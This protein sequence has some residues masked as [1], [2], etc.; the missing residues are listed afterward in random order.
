MNNL[1]S[2]ALKFTGQGDSITVS[3]T[4]FQEETHAKYQIVVKDTGI[5]MSEEFLPQLFEPYARETRFTAQKITGTGL[6]MPIVKNLVTQMSGQIQVESHL[7]QGTTFTLVLP[8]EAV[9]SQ[10]MEKTEDRETDQKSAQPAASGLT[11]RRILL[12]EDNEVNMEIATEILTSAGLEVT[13]AWN[14]QE[15][16]EQ[17]AS[18]QPFF[19]D[20]ILM[21]M[22]MP[23]MD[24]C[25]A[26]KQ[27]RYR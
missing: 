13:Q 22:Q 10:E 19:F 14:G 21:D 3:V 6:G 11:G 24:G 27:I 16:V 12:A 5:G 8:L 1:L 26:A 7:G 17:F 4:Q 20:A 9:R 2:N 15:A 23:Q 18:S 25:T